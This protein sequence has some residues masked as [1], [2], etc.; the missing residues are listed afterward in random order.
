MSVQAVPYPEARPRGVSA[1]SPRC[2][3]RPVDVHE[4]PR[5]API[6]VIPRG[7]PVPLMPPQRMAWYDTAL[8]LADSGSEC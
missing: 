2:Y 4:P 6:E 8:P 5:L 3:W 1:T 7:S